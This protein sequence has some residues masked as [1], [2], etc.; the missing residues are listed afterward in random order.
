MQSKDITGQVISHYRV[1]ECI[2]QGG[3]GVVYRAFDLQLERDVALKMLS[4]EALSAP[5]AKKRLKREA[6]S[7]SAINHPNVAHVYEVGEAGPICFIAM[8]FVEGEMLA[9]RIS[10]QALDQP[11]IL[12]LAVQIAGALAAA[13]AKGIIHRDIKPANILVTRDNRVKVLDFGLA[14]ARAAEAE[15][16]FPQT[17]TAANIVMGTV[18]YMSPEQALGHEVD[19]RS[20][21]FSFGAVLYQMATGSL[22]FRGRNSTELLAHVLQSEPEPIASSN[23]AITPDLSR[24]IARCLE[25]DRDRR[26][27]SMEDVLVD[28]RTLT[29]DHRSGMVAPSARKRVI[30]KRYL[31]VLLSILLCVAVAALGFGLYRHFARASLD[32][33]AILPL[34][35]KSGDA[36]LDYLSDG[37]SESVINRVSRVR[38]V[39][40]RPRGSVIRYK[41]KEIDAQAVG[42]QLDVKAVLTGR[43][44]LQNGDLLISVELTDVGNNRQ[45]WGDQYKR[46]AAAVYEIQEEISREVA[47]NLRMP[48]TDQDRRLLAQQDTRNTDAYQL[49]LKGRYFWNKR[50]V[51][52]LSKAIDY[53]QQAI[54]K[55]PNY[56]LAYSGLADCYIFQ[57][58]LIRPADIFPKAK[59]AVMKAL[60]QDPNLAEPY[61]TLGYIALH[62]DWNWSDAE[63][64]F[65]RSFERNPNYPTAHSMYA[66]YLS[67]RGRLREALDE[68]RRAQELD[69]LALG[70]STGI[71][72]CYYF[73][74]QYDRAIA[75]YR[76]TLEIDPSF[77]L[78]HFDL[79]GALG[80]KKQFA[81]AIAEFQAGFKTNPNDAGATAELGYVYAKAG[82]GV[83][84]Q[85]TLE[86]LQDLSSKR[87]VAPYFPALVHAGR[88]DREQALAYLEQAFE[89][90][91]SP[92]VFLNVEPKFSE[93]RP[94][95][96]FQSLL[97]RL[98]LADD[99]PI[100]PRR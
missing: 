94:D 46:P 1:M 23:P 7:A 72:L 41:G 51:E 19:P 64:A 58:N 40:V 42:K 65:R 18:E 17:L 10:G 63:M 73:A 16:G 24:I 80:Q 11:E 32:S 34:V 22:P 52:G 82:R 66:R 33:L 68:M 44:L 81:E 12:H 59:A 25:K 9:Q 99:K 78:A 45:V 90:R 74:G 79:G 93:L 92:M 89:E 100:G 86:T 28:F 84:A 50:T 83:E 30:P 62:Y 6:K 5:G 67:V 14:K 3:M 36:S 47:R 21:I 39:T 87:Y 43:M 97:R 95:P 15:D 35:N 26:Y 76:K 85:K 27:Q 55:D 69:P 98:Q 71:G 48:I 4:P 91:A 49:Y 31:A 70:V 56:A 88:G 77:A 60:E 54:A 37:I 2:G 20:D 29:G 75:Q 13:H 96:R 61:A 53:F 38:S 57:G 8:E